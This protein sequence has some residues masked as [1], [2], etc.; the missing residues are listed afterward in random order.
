M[1][2][3]LANLNSVGNKSDINQSNI[4]ILRESIERLSKYR[5]V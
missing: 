1:Y 2:K 4:M 3:M 5:R